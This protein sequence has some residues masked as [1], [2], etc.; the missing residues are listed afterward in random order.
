MCIE[1]TIIV[2]FDIVLKDFFV[3]IAGTYLGIALV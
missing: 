3:F 1:Y 2:G